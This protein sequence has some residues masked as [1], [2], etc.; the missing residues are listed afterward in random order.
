MNQSGMPWWQ[1]RVYVLLLIVLAGVPF[2]W[3]S[4]PPLVDLPG[5]MGRYRVQLDISS[6]PFFQLYYDFKWGLIANLGVDLLV[7]VFGPLIGLEPSIKAIVIAIPMITVAGM[8]LIAREAHGRV[9]ATAAFAL[10]LSIGYPLHFGFV[11]FAL[12]MGLALLAFGCWMRL[13]RLGKSGLRMALFVPIGIAIWFVHVY[14]WGLL[15]LM[16]GAYE[17]HRAGWRRTL[18]AVL[19]CLPLLPPLLL[20]IIW[21]GEANSESDGWF[22]L[23]SK[24]IW[25]IGGLREEH[26][27]FD[28]SSSV[29]LL[30]LPLVPIG[31]G[32]WHEKPGLNSMLALAT[33]LLAIAY[34]CIPRILM[35]SAYADMRLAPFLIA[36]WVLAANPKIF[37]RRMQHILAV[38]GLVFFLLRTGMTTEHLARLDRAFAAQ[39]EALPHIP[40]NSRVFAQISLPCQI[41]WA[42]SRMD[43]LSSMATV[44]RNAFV[45][46][47][48]DMPGAQLLRI[49][50]PQIKTWDKDP[51]QIARPNECPQPLGNTYDQAMRHFPRYAYDYL[52]LID[53]TPDRLPQHDPTLTLIWQGQKSGALYRIGSATQ[54]SDTP[55]G[56]EPLTSQ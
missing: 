35:G 11:N 7:Q 50:H 27:Y 9:P 56:R 34:F 5:H 39:M 25:L 29:G 14:G 21:R 36:I 4:L 10:P 55:N 18:H 43:H 17:W 3:P 2:W 41:S 20:M 46:D 37:S 33:A 1:S 51:T 22:S 54:A 52:W 30:A 15:G 49:H 8:L 48:W 6:N 40:R 13:D 23:M 45:N 47:Q 26:R 16:V 19:T 38:L 28:I 31:I 32:R 42:S 53:F 44:R 12:S 24:Y